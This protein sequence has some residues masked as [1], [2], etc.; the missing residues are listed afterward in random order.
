MRANTAARA[1][2]AV[3]LVAIA[4]LATAADRVAVRVGVHPE[5]TRVVIDWS[6]NVPYQ[7]AR[8]GDTWRIQFDRPATLDLGSV[9]RGRPPLLQAATQGATGS[10]VTLRLQVA[11]NTTLEHRRLDG[12]VVLDLRRDKA[13]AAPPAKPAEGKADKAKPTEPSPQVA[14]LEIPLPEAKPAPPAA[15]AP[16]P[17][18]EAVAAQPVAPAPIEPVRVA[19]A[20]PAQRLAVFLEGIGESARLIFPWTET[21]AAAAFTRGKQVWLVFDRPAR[22]ELDA[23]APTRTPSILRAEQIAIG[24]GTALRLTLRQEQT[25]VLMRRQTGWVVGFVAVG[26]PPVVPIAVKPQPAAPGGGRLFLPVGEPGRRL[27]LIDPDSG[28]ALQVV[29]VLSTAHGVAEARDYLEFRLLATAQGV[30]LTPRAEAVEA[31]PITGGVEITARQGLMLSRAPDPL[32]TKVT[33]GGSGRGGLFPYDAWRGTNEDFAKAKQ[34]AQHVVTDAAPEAR[35]AARFG[36]AG[37]YFS[38]GLATDALAVLSLIGK[39]DPLLPRRPEF[40]AMRGAARLLAGKL[41]EARADLDQ[42]LLDG[43]PEVAL[44]RGAMAQGIGDSKRA[45]RELAFGAGAMDLFPAEARLRFNLALVDAALAT[46]DLKL[47]QTALAAVDADRAGSRISAEAEYRRGRLQEA[48]GQSEEALGS[49]DRTVAMEWRPARARADLARIDLMQRTGKL[50]ELAVVDRLEGMRFAWRGD[51]L[52]VDIRRR[53]ARAYATAGK[54]RDAL[55]TLRQL[56]ARQPKDGALARSLD[57]ELRRTFTDVYL[58]PPHPKVT[59]VSALALYEENPDLAP[60]GEQGG[61][62]AR[63]LADRLVEIDLLD[64]AAAL[65]RSHANALPAGAMKARGM[66]RVAAIQLLDRQPDAALVTLREAAAL[67]ADQALVEERRLLQARALTDLNRVPEALAL[68]EPATDRAAREIRAELLWR[69]SRWADAAAALRELLGAQG[70]AQEPLGDTERRQVLQMAIALARAGDRRGTEGLKRDWAARMAGTPEAEA[71][72]VLTERPDVQDV[73]F[74]QL[75]SQV[76]GIGEL[77]AMMT[78]YRA[79]PQG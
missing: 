72:R 57:A 68:L 71:F 25:P 74:R 51:A 32:E 36:L 76:A 43:R 54:H 9:A 10:G 65:L 58:G 49:Y 70:T 21:T 34:A 20:L 11:P 41:A 17:A 44:W 52:E 12:R 39:D 18:P 1:V 64:R 2:M 47:A 31:R 3:I 5:H 53:L 37:F 28:D 42:P 73:A 6:G 59:P 14:A 50:D 78:R 55:T 77:E 15:P 61:E 38:H 13:S 33:T 29:P 62:V 22:L 75:A 16:A 7:V 79:K 19:P 48:R 40:I 4:G 8:D 35:D 23:L 26:T 60:G 24:D 45:K 67:T 46:E 66:T 69:E 56:L 30:A 63:R 27:D